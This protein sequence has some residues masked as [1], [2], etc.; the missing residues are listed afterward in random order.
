MALGVAVRVVEVEFL[1]QEIG[2]LGPVDEFAAVMGAARR[3]TQWQEAATAS[4]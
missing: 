3:H 1:A 2:Q 4:A